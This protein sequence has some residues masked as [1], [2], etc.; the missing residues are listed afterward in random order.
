M[1]IERKI[2][3]LLELFID[4]LVHFK[5]FIKLQYLLTLA[6]LTI[7]DLFYEDFITNDF[8]QDYINW[9]NTKHIK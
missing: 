7:D 5:K 2:N 1:E 3:Y 8:R 4:E 9:K 6:E